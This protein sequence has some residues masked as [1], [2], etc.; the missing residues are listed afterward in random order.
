MLELFKVSIDDEFIRMNFSSEL[1]DMM[2][3]QEIEGVLSDEEQKQIVSTV[4]TI[5]DKLQK[6]IDVDLK[7]YFIARHYDEVLELMTRE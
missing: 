3:E 1:R 4:N 5:L 6:K 2:S 7:T